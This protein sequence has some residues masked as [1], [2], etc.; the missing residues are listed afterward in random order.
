MSPIRSWPKSACV[1]TPKI[2]MPGCG[3]TAGAG[4]GPGAARGAAT[5][6]LPADGVRA[7]PGW[8]PAAQ[9]HA[10]ACRVVAAP[11]AA[12]GPRPA[13]AAPRLFLDELAPSLVEW[14]ERL[15]GRDGRLDL[16]VV[17]RVFRL[18]WLL[19][20]DEVRR[21]DLAAVD[22]DGPLAE[23]RVVRRQ[24]L[25]LGDDLGAFVALERLDSLQ[26]VQRPRVNARVDHRRMDPPIALREPLRERARFLVEIPI[27]GLGEGEPLGF[28][29]AERVHVGEEDQETRELLA[30]LHDAELGALLDG[31]GGVAAGVG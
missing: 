29:E 25:H 17:P 2:V 18:G 19:H 24:L 30:A 14:P 1:G 11:L 9:G 4:R 23:E 15:L 13:P 26:V 12:P 27:E 28:L 3:V 16:V 20:L 5:R 21:M 6:S 8:S 31:V 10:H 7:A 22:A